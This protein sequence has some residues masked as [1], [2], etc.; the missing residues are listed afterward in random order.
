MLKSNLFTISHIRSSY[1]WFNGWCNNGCFVVHIHSTHFATDISIRR[2]MVSSITAYVATTNSFSFLLAF[3]LFSLFLSPSLSPS[4]SPHT[5]P[6]YSPPP[7]NRT[8]RLN[9]PFI[10]CRK[11]S[12]YLLLRDTSLIP[13][14]LWFEYTATRQEVRA[15]TRKLIN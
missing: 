4:L 9:I 15:R 10:S 2:F 8:N 3:S 1:C 7:Q 12:E 6:S 11:L 5:L 14:I 13:N